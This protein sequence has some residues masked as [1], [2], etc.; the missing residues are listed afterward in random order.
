MVDKVSAY[1]VIM[2]AFYLDTDEVSELNGGFNFSTVNN[3]FFL[4][5]SP[6]S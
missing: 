2:K 6:I 5:Q 1:G 4:V 3:T